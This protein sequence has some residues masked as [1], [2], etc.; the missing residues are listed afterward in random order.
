MR[1]PYSTTLEAVTKK[2][3]RI[4]ATLEGRSDNEILEEL[5]EKYFKQ[6]KTPE[7]EGDKKC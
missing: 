4:Q 5:L 1:E 7:I 3:L 2:R 6:K